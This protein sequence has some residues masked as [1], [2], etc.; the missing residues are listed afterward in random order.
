[1]S[2]SLLK[3]TSS[4]LTRTLSSLT[5]SPIKG[6]F[7]GTII[8][9]IIQFSS[10]SVIMVIGFVNARLLN[11]K[12]AIP[13][14]MGANI[15]T[16]LKIWLF[17]YF[18][19]NLNFGEFA[20]PLIGLS[21]PFLFSKKNNNRMYGEAII[22]FG[23]IFISLEFLKLLLPNISSHPEWV[24][25]IK[26]FTD[27]GMF[28]IILFIIIGFFTTVLVQS[29]SAVIAFTM[30]MCNQGW[31]PF[32]MAAAMVI[33]D[34]IGT[35][36]MPNIAAFVAGKEAK[37]IARFHFLFNLFG[38]LWFILLYHTFL[39]FIDLS[40]TFLYGKSPYINALAIPF[41]LA[42]LHT[43]FNVV[44]SIILIGFIP[45]IDSLL[46]KLYSNSTDVKT[47]KLS[48]IK[49]NLTSTSEL[50]LLTA[51]LEIV[52]Y[53]KKMS[54]QFQLIPQVLIEKD[55]SEY[56]ELLAKIDN[57]QNISKQISIDINQYLSRIAES[58]LSPKSIQIHRIMLNIIEQLDNISQLNKQLASTIDNKNKQNL[59]FTQELRDNLNK[60][61]NLTSL[62]F[63]TLLANLADEY[64]KAD[65]GKSLEIEQKINEL[66]NKLKVEYLNNIND[67]EY[68][69]KNGIAYN[70]MVSITEKIGDYIF[71][72]STSMT[73]IKNT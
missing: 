19:F 3:F 37:Q 32:P 30:V 15:G 18:G 44:N 62:A 12:R 24:Q 63:N 52:E 45:R 33:G 34:N 17:M 28:S 36:I 10:A 51:R 50:S 65:F 59:W 57:Y 60:L 1:M 35:T 71:E 66:R 67:S 11:V 41:A 5:S 2:E 25:M 22:G 16:T 6:V 43:A 14:I 48:F 56:A 39:N 69:Y 42:F 26:G 13:L 9:S 47:N 21:F 49:D 8:T 58:S 54:H 46:I 20:L 31:L 27:N 72:I 70:Q 55:E 64:E 23:L 4:K 29:S 7:I 40:T 68:P 73:E 38:A 61:F 53:A